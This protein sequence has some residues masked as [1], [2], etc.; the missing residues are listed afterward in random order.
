MIT[1]T[2]KFSDLKKRLR[3]ILLRCAGSGESMIVE[4]PRNQRVIIQRLVAEDEDLLV[5]DLIESNPAFRELLENSK[6]GPRK[7]FVPRR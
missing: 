3:S 5:D 1:K 4:L 6:K 2:V 7:P